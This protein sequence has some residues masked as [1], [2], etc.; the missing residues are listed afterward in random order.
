MEFPSEE[1]TACGMAM[2]FGDPDANVNRLRMPRQR[3]EEFVR[4]I[5]FDALVR[6]VAPERS[7]ACRTGLSY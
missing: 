5:G 6:A 2:G 1:V 7:E 4:M 3:V